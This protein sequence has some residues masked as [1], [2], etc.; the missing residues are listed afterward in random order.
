MAIGSSCYAIQLWWEVQLGVS[1][2]ASVIKN[3]TGKE[4]E[5]REDGGGDSRVVCNVEQVQTHGQSTKVVVSCEVGE[6]DCRKERKVELLA[7]VS[8]RGAEVN[9]T[10][11]SMQ[12][13]WEEIPNIGPITQGSSS[14]GRV[15]EMV[16]ERRPNEEG[17]VS[18]ILKDSLEV[19]RPTS[20]SLKAQS[21]WDDPI[22]KL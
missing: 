21:W 9:V 14:L 20:E 7:L 3:G 15:R 13:V 10:R 17:Q 6:S 1:E 4:Q 8:A 18:V 16:L 12:S 2:V 22:L 5:V 11:G 19:G